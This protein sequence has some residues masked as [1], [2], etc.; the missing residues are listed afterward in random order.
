M[1][2]EGRFWEVAL[3][4]EVSI[5]MAMVGIIIVEN[6]LQDPMDAN[7]VKDLMVE[8]KVV[9]DSIVEDTVAED[10]VNKNR[11]LFVNSNSN[12]YSSYYV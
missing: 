8:D 7:R 9:A 12:L 4:M 3:I 2:M 11:E 5:I 1:V 6:M 10:A